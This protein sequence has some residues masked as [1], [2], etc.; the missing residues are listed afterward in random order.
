M[1]FLFHMQFRTR[2]FNVRSTP[3]ARERPTRA[4][5]FARL[6]KRPTLAQ[7]SGETSRHGAVP[8]RTINPSGRC[9]A[10]SSLLALLHALH[11]QRQLSGTVRP[12][13][14]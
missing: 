4:F 3:N 6:A 10:Q 7:P 12:P 13:F 11:S 5:G 8:N 2:F 9:T 14:D 1:Q